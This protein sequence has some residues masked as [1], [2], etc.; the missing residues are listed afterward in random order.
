MEFKELLEL[1]PGER[2]EYPEVLNDDAGLGIVDNEEGTH[3][4]PSWGRRKDN[5]KRRVILRMSSFIGMSSDAEH[6]YGKLE[7]QGVDMAYNDRPHCSTFGDEDKDPLSG[8]TYR[9]QLKRRV[10][11]EDKDKDKTARWEAEI[12]WDG[13]RVGSLTDRFNSKEDLINFATEVFNTRF[14]GDWEFKIDK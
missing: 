1:S 11:Q 6:Y 5:L 2:Y 9:I 8:Y 4:I 14:K 10:T 12:K 13:Y 7:V 3:S